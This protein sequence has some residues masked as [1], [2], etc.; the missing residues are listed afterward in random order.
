MS[1]FG[2]TKALAKQTARRSVKPK[3]P[4]AV[5]VAA[6][7]PPV[8]EPRVPHVVAS[9]AADVGQIE[10]ARANRLTA[11]NLNEFDLGADWQPNF[12][13]IQT[14]DDV[15]AVIAETAEVNKTK[16]Q[17]ARRGQVTNEQLTALAA[18]LDIG[19]HVVRGVIERETGGVLNPETILAARQV[20][21]SSAN[22]LLNL[23]TKVKAGQASDLDRIAFRRQFE[24]HA[25]YQRQFMGARAEAGRA[26]NAFAIPVGSD[27]G[28]IARLKN[29]VES[30]HGRDTEQLAS[31]LTSIDSLSG[32]NRL[33]R[34]YS[35]SR[36]MGV[37]QELFVNS[38]L[39]SLRT[40]EVNAFG[41]ALFAGMNVAERAIAARIG[42]LLTGDE[43]VMVGEASAQMFGMLSGWKDALRYAG[44]AFKTGRPTDDAV[45][46]EV[47]TPRAISSANLLPPDAPAGLARAL[48]GLGTFL[49]IPTERVMLPVDEFFKTLANRAEMS[50]LAYLDAMHKAS[51]QPMTEAEIGES[52]RRFLDNPPEGALAAAGDYARYA[53][54]QTPMG[55]AGRAITRGLNLV[56]GARLIAPFIQTPGNLLKAGLLERSPLAVFSADFRAAMR[57]GG[58]RRD[59]ALARVSMGSLTVGLAAL[60]AS[61]G[62][63]TG[64]GPT[65]PD[66]RKILELS[67]WQPY[68]IRYTDPATGATRYQSY[69]RA[70][71]LAYVLGATADAVEMLAYVDYDDELRTE[72]E[73][74]NLIAASLVAGVANNTMSKTYMSGIIDFS[75]MLGDPKRYAA[76]WAGRLA[77]AF[78]P[79]SAMR[80]DLA[81]IQDPYVREAWT[82]N[83]RIKVESGIPG[84]SEKVP[85]RR[86]LFGEPVRH[87]G[88]SLLGVMSAFP[89]T[90]AK[91]DPVLDEVIRVMKGTREVPLTMPGRRVEGMRLSV[92]EYD[93]LV[94]IARAEPGEDGKTFKERLS[95]L[96]DS[97]V[98]Q[99]ATDDYRKLLIRSVQESTDAA[100]RAQL[101]RDNPLFAERIAGYRLKKAARLFGDLEE[102][103]A[104]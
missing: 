35:R 54:F 70:E 6:D 49:R 19:E 14:T 96:F 72:E 102:S 9:Q 31:I 84:Y 22:R 25:E 82:L 36:L 74:F 94:R 10:T 89:D 39:S 11:A 97:D 91:R 104:P 52:I 34:E 38:I 100:A 61:S 16:I 45:K 17:E 101:E 37:T 81:R 85:P 48:D 4:P 57:A 12:D 66:A 68:S 18:D 33:T 42:R 103:A 95:E 76:S 15:K 92:Q 77:G 43:H 62:T 13:R 27:V 93:E 41:N 83:E 78:I 60:A 1:D 99:L 28:Q 75:E 44:K 21:N 20:L 98:Y 2:L 65:N 59:L 55:P 40:H 73:S 56:P 86:D 79:Y 51:A 29:V 23:A 3:V 71:P 67:G 50:R 8:V 46:F 7:V 88:G 32:V 53:T 47:Q 64:G 5:V 87:R 80:R 69:A 26:L 90:N 30:M 58:S 24:F 63:I